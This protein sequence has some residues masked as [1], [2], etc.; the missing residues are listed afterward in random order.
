[1]AGSMLGTPFDGHINGDLAPAPGERNRRFSGQLTVGQLDLRALTELVLGPDQ[2]F[3]EGDETSIWPAAFFG[4]PLLDG[5]DITLDLRADRLRLDEETA[6]RSTRAELRLTPTLLRLDGLNGGYSGG[7]LEGSLSL[8]RSD[9]EGA[10]TGR[11]KLTDADLQQLAWRR[12]DRSVASGTLDVYL[13]FEG[14]GRSI[15]SIVAGLNGG[16]TFAVKEGEFRGLNPQAFQ[17]VTRAVDAGLDLQDDKIEEVFVSHMAAGSLPFDKVEG[18][19]TLVGGR[20]SARN[21]VV[22]SEKA[23]VFGSAGLD[24]NTYKLD[25]D[26]SVKVDPEE[27]AVTGAEPQVGL[28]FQG[29]VEVPVRKIDIAPFTA[30]LTLRAFEQEVERVERLQAEILERDRFAR[31]LKRQRQAKA[32][33]EREALAAAEAAAQAAEEERLRLEERQE[34]GS[35]TNAQERGNSN[36]PA[37]QQQQT[38]NVTA[39]QNLQ[40]TD[41]IKAV[42][43]ASDGSLNLT[44]TIAAPRAKLESDLPPLDG[45]V[46]IEDLINGQ[47]SIPAR[48]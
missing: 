22:D 26:F 46:T 43:D 5:L 17:L 20:L 41:R 47:F 12:G 48:Q 32:R 24:L 27:N 14:A 9:A 2:W 8:R 25:A 7:K 44:G 19:L 18:T 21:V 1:M 10:A 16:G 38:E 36:S 4:A 31:E 3:S 33:R 15:A 30:Y 13:E 40:L 39:D 34:N 37:P 45:P 29:D 35:G 42:L 23:E 28:L 6:L 11:I